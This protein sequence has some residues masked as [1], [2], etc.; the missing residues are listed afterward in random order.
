M[1]ETRLEPG[2]VVPESDD[3]L[4]SRCFLAECIAERSLCGSMVGDSESEELE[5]EAECE[6][7]GGLFSSTTSWTIL[8]TRGRGLAILLGCTGGDRFA[9]RERFNGR[10]GDVRSSL[11]E[12]DAKF[13]ERVGATGEPLD[14]DGPREDLDRKPAWNLLG[15][16]GSSVVD[17]GI[18]RLGLESE[19]VSAEPRYDGR[20]GI[21]SVGLSGEIRSGDESAN[22]LGVFSK[23]AKVPSSVSSSRHRTARFRGD[24][25]LEGVNES[26]LRT[27]PTL[28]R[29]GD[30][31]IGDAESCK[32]LGTDENAGGATGLTLI[33]MAFFRF[34]VP[35]LV[36]GCISTGINEP[37]GLTT[38]DAAE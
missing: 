38:L 6:L 18:S 28:R 15:L 30:D 36:G 16:A 37:S 9:V 35:R 25:L 20:M 12:E 7:P 32:L 13:R 2:H 23:S 14:S 21:C 27:A 8:P 19:M 31:F 26:P 34:G 17:S 11:S 10:R 24:F 33:A 29:R 5:A 4:R 22:F 1:D 3:I